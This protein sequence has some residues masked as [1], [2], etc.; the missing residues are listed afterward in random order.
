M[1]AMDQMVDARVKIIQEKIY[2]NYR[3]ANRIQ[4]EVYDPAR[5]KYSK[6]LKEL[7]SPIP[8]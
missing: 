3:E 1:E 2:S 5:E 7:T 8:F 6:L 4:D